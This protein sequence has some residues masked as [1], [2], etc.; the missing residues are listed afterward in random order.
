MMVIMMVMIM[1][2]MMVVMMVMM[3]VMMMVMVVI[4][5]VRM[6][7]MMVMEQHTIF[8]A[9]QDHPHLMMVMVVMI[10]VMLMMQIL[11]LIV[12]TWSISPSLSMSSSSR[13]KMLKQRVPFSRIAAL[14][15][16]ENLKTF[17]LTHF[18]LHSTMG[19]C[20]QGFL[21]QNIIIC[22]L[23]P[24]TAKRAQWIFQYYFFYSH[25]VPVKKQNFIFTSDIFSKFLWCLQSHSVPAYLQV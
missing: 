7:F 13:R 24:S 6:M 10:M 2:M 19:R 25:P 5:T 3:R 4:M 17:T 16:S 20:W 15:S 8:W 11:C 14:K 1:V 23:A 9:A 21:L 22:D 12:E 18:Q